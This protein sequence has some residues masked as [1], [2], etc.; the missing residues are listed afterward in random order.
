MFVEAVV[1][2]C[3]CC[4]ATVSLLHF[5]QRLVLFVDVI[6]DD[7]YA[8]LHG[9]AS[10]NV[11][12]FRRIVQKLGA[13]MPVVL[14]GLTLARLGGDLPTFSVVMHDLIAD[15]RVLRDQGSF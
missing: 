10:A 4:C 1:M 5:S 8:V 13:R 15:L 9:F 6:A 3:D 11:E 14:E 12:Q 7:L 2:V